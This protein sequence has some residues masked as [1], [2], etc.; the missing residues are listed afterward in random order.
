LALP[1]PASSPPRPDRLLAAAPA[2]RRSAAATLPPAPPPAPGF[3][4]F[5]PVAAEAP[6]STATGRAVALEH[7]PYR[8]RFGPD[9]EVALR[10]FGGSRETEAAVAAGLAYLA[11]LQAPEGF[12]GSPD[13]RHEKYRHVAIG[14]TALCLL[15]FLGAGHTPGAGTEY[16]PVAARAVDF[17][18]A[19]QDPATGHFGDSNA[20]SHGV[21]T[22]ALA[23]CYALT[24]DPRL[25]S[26][27]ERAVAWI[28][29]H[30][31]KSRSPERDGGWGYYYPDG[32]VWQNDTWPRVS[33]TSWQVMALESARLGGL[34]VPDRAFAAARRYLRNSVDPRRGWFRYSHDPSRLESAYPTLP[35]STP[36]GLFAASLL[37]EDLEDPWYARARAFLRE[38]AP[39]GYR[40]ESEDAFVSRATGNLYF[41]YYGSLA[42]FRIGG[43][44]WE[45]WNERMKTTLLEAQE[46]DGSWRPI[47]LYARYAGDDD[48]DRSY[49]TAM[50]VLSLE[51]YYRYFTPLLQVK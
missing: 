8:N 23:E 2:L 19:V 45:R 29:R 11:G 35:A 32:A 51:V 24:R 50:C 31:I 46:E 27:L 48:H 42:S 30:Q 18:L 34:E 16:A 33:V 4:S 5:S 26:P 6:T 3:R 7:T 44:D 47:S 22:Y 1:P 36:A 12:W 10:E 39:S 28:L 41:W 9:K 40:F 21:S 37:G 17:L 13:D 43:D 25:R 38:R 49:T 20:Y 15:A 14:K